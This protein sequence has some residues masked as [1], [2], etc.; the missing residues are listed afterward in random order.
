[1]PPTDATPSQAPSRGLLVTL[2]VVV[3]AAI[4]YLAW[5]AATPPGPPSNETR[6]SRAQEQAARTSASLDVRLSALNQAAPQPAQAERNPF[7]FEAKPPPLTV[8][9]PGGRANGFN[10][11]PG[12]RGMGPGSGPPAPPTVPPIPLRFIGT[13]AG[14][15]QGE[16]AIFV[17]AD[18]RGTPVYGREGQLVLGQY[19]IV[20][21]GIESVVMEYADGRGRQTIPLRGQ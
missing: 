14:R 20:K 13:L 19:R 18:G 16:V 8:S 5:P 4:V 1:M 15:Q 3:I 2:G 11:L 10:G 17:Q 9:Q 12:T 21:I 6:T 7:R